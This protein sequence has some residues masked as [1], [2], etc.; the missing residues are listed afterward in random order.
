M[1]GQ[2]VMEEHLDSEIRTQDHWL[3]EQPWVISV[4]SL[5]FMF[6]LSIKH[7]VVMVSQGQSPASPWESRT[8]LGTVRGDVTQSAIFPVSN[9]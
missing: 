9:L 3:A 5:G 2:G 6:F 7:L 8:A 4:F 1:Q